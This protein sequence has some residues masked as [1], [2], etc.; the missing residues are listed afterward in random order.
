MKWQK[1]SLK[2]LKEDR[3]LVKEELSDVVKSLTDITKKEKHISQD[4]V[5]EINEFQLVIE[6]SLAKI[7]DLDKQLQVQMNNLRLR[8]ELID[9]L[10]VSWAF[11]AKIRVV[12]NKANK[13]CNIKSESRKLEVAKC[14]TAS[15]KKSSL[16]AEASV[17]P[18]IFY[19]DFMSV[20]LTQ[21]KM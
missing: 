3:E 21:Y 2:Q 8:K 13:L 11:A 20:C 10:T 18:E 19:L 6:P 7:R 9:E 15:Q 12:L 16:F 14:L 17:L 5:S 4:L 1:G